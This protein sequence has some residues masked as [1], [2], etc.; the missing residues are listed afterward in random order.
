MVVYGDNMGHSTMNNKH[1]LQK[2]QQYIH[3]VGGNICAETLSAINS[4]PVCQ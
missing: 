4:Y 2:L 3:D 1:T